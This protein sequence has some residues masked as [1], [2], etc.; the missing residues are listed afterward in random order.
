M[1]PITNSATSLQ[2]FCNH[3]PWA[4]FP[5][6]LWVSTGSHSFCEANSRG[7]WA[8]WH[9][10]TLELSML[11]GLN[12]KMLP[13]DQNLPIIP[14]KMPLQGERG[15]FFFVFFFNFFIFFYT[16]VCTSK[17]KSVQGSTSTDQSQ[18]TTSQGSYHVHDM[19]CICPPTSPYTTSPYP[20]FLASA[21]LSSNQI[22]PTDN[23]WPNSN[24][25]NGVISG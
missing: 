21:N 23:V 20:T 10:L 4:V 9:P 8:W 18:S 2:L 25:A 17:V 7:S 1:S 6:L 3:L 22:V 15:V 19:S 24:D 12:Q 16:S 5:L 11:M 13:P 14:E